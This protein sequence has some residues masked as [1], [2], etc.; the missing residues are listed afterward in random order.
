[1]WVSWRAYVRGVRITLRRNVEY[2][3]YLLELLVLSYA[4]SWSR[5][6][7]ILFGSLS[8]ILLSGYQNKHPGSF[9][10]FPRLLC[11]SQTETPRTD[12]PQTGTPMLLLR[13]RLQ[14]TELL[15]TR[16]CQMGTLPILKVRFLT[17]RLEYVAKSHRSGK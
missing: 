12:M 1:M 2:K 17:S 11:L 9:N 15:R 16:N 5:A 7:R 8:S 3:E 13:A 10:C 4:T 6:F 14:L